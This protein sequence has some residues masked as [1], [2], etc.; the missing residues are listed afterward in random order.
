MQQHRFIVCPFYRYECEKVIVT[1]ELS[2]SDIIC[3]RDYS[4]ACPME[5]YLDSSNLCRSAFADGTVGGVDFRNQTPQ[6][7]AVK[8]MSFGTEFP[9]RKNGI[10]LEYTKQQSNCKLNEAQLCP[11]SW[12][13]QNGRCIANYGMSRN[14]RCGVYTNLK[15]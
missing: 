6:E 1:E 11:H 15:N 9:C 7:K 3:D 10:R 13:E 8:A 12:I 2:D 14:Y 5:W 4:V